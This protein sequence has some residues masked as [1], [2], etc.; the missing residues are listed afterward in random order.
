ML[1]SQPASECGLQLWILYPKFDF[2]LIQYK[3]Q[4][5]TGKETSTTTQTTAVKINYMRPTLQQHIPSTSNCNSVEVITA[6][7][8]CNFIIISNNITGSRTRNLLV[9]TQEYDS[10]VRSGFAGG[11][12]NFRCLWTVTDAFKLQNT[13]GRRAVLSSESELN[14]L[15]E[16]EFSAAFYLVRAP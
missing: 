4:E 6:K 8:P 3:L 1:T 2:F 7:S 13:S 14:L 16:R 10:E 5:E 9:V 12:Q 11:S 15:C